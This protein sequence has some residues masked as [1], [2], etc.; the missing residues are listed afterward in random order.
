M[1]KPA[2][3]RLEGELEGQAQVLRVNAMSRVGATL[4]GRYGVRGV[5]TFLVF[6]GAGE[7]IYGQAGRPNQEAIKATVLGLQMP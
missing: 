2:V 6:D 1:S 5:P 7:V 4:A 3:D